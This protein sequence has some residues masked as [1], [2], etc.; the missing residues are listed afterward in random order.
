MDFIFLNEKPLH[1]TNFI[2]AI[3]F[4]RMS[5]EEMKPY[6]LKKIMIHDKLRSKLVEKYGGLY[7]EKMCDDEIRIKWDT[8]CQKVTGIHTQ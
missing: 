4:E 7:W 1:K 8:L 6:F 3:P 5:Y 2:G